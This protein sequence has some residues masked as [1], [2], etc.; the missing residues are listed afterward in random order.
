MVTE[1]KLRRWCRDAE[2]AYEAAINQG[3]H[4]HTPTNIP[5]R[6]G[7]ELAY[8]AG[9]QAY[10]DHK[11]GATSVSGWRLDEETWL[12]VLAAELRPRSQ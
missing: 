10:Q 11:N 1:R 9:K 12:R 8:L 3:F 2:R 7:C 6:Y 4:G 5:K